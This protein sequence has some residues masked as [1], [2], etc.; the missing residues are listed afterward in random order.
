MLAA[1]GRLELASLWPHGLCNASHSQG[2]G[3]RPPFSPSGWR[4]GRGWSPH[5]PSFPRLTSQG[6]CPRSPSPSGGSQKGV[7]GPAAPPSWGSLEVQI[8]RAHPILQI[9]NTGVGTSTRF[10]RVTMV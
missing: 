4:A 10:K 7:S 8:L 9:R 5:E 3:W 1:Q 6:C 2:Q